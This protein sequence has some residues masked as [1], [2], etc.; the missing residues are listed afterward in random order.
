LNKEYKTRIIISE[1][2]RA[3][4]TGDFQTRPLGDVVVKGKSKAVQIFEV[5]VPAPLVEEVK[6]I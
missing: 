3:R 1:G 4:L 5:L 2:T 6:A